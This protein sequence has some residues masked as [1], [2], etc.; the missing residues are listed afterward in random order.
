M[1]IRCWTRLSLGDNNLFGTLSPY[2]LGPSVENQ[3]K[4]MSTEK[5][6]I[7]SDLLDSLD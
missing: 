6:E 3:E 2:S 4:K 1:T 7:K 5:N